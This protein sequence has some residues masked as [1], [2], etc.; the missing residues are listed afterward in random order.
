MIGETRGSVW[1]VTGSQHLYG[2]ET[3]RQVH[4]HSRALAQALNDSP[5]IPVAIVGREPLTDADGIRRVLADAGSDDDC[6]GVIAW[7]HTFSPARMWIGGL[8]TLRKPLLHLHT[9]FDRELPWSEIDMDYMNL[10]QS[11][12]GDR[13]FGYVETRMRVARKT[14]VGHWS[15]RLLQERIGNW[16]R[17]A[18]GWQEAQRLRIARFGDNMR[19]VAVTEGDKVGAQITF[20]ASVNGYGVDTLSDAVEH[21]S[22]AAVHELLE[23]YDDAYEVVPEL[24]PDGPRRESLAAAAQIEVGLRSLLLDGGFGAFT[25]TFEDLGRLRQLPGIA[26]QRLM[27]DGYGFGAEG[28]WKTAMLLRVLKVMAD[29]L[30]GGTS[31]ME[32]YVYHLG[33]GSAKTLGAHMLEVC[34]S[35]AAERPSCEIHPL[36]IGGRED[37]VRLVFTAPPGPAVLVC[38]IDVGGRLRLVA[39]EVDVVAPD[40]PLPRL[41]VARAVWEPRPELSTAAEAWLTAGGSHHSVFTTALRMEAV[42]DLAQIAGVELV[43]IDESTT[44]PQFANELRWNSAYHHLARGL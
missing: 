14:V 2:E 30:T 10:N 6:I 23:R 11:A 31:F 21:A 1:F 29:G 44:I 12:H 33:P 42:R 7:M 13:E 39:N 22:D 41:P 19:D 8:N 32:D 25:D 28:D 27:A 3:L 40:Q 36:S 35:I 15:D 17:A 26:V 38:L 37:P 43:V 34:P 18:C 20:G 9:Q 5:S 16:V 4:D 24:R